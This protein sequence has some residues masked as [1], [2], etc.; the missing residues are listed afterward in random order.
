MQM[1]RRRAISSVGALIAMGAPRMSL[2]Q[3]GP[4]QLGA[5]VPLTGSG[6]SYGPPMAESI[7]WVI[8]Q[9][10]DLGGIKGRS[11]NLTIEDDETNPDSGVRGARKLIDVNRVSAIMG[12]WASSVTMAVAPLC[13]QSQTFLTTDSGS[14]RITQLPHQGYLIRTEPTT[15]LIVTKI[16]NFLADLGVK[17]AYMLSAQTPFAEIAKDTLSRVLSG[18]GSSMLGQTVYDREKTTFRSEIDIAM[19]GNPDLIF[20]DGYSPDVAVLLRELYQTGYT[21]KKLA[22][23]YAVNEKLLATIPTEATEGVITVTPAS[24]V[25]TPSYARLADH[26]KVKEVDSYTCEAYDQANLVCLAL[27]NAAQPNGTGIRD[28]IHSVSD[29]GGT[30]VYSA[31]DGIRALR[32]GTKKI[33]YSGVSG[34][35]IFNKLGDIVDVKA[36]FETVHNGKADLLK[37]T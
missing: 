17:R 35:C 23:A 9:V 25:G 16:G 7:K 28:A 26:L 14:D 32:A 19:K 4:I 34:P 27:Q 1:N 30:V 24:E 13:W 10:N 22:R 11:L 21:G 18:R 33:K 2:A 6:S 12:T 3:S 36:R 8:Q 31:V 37:I 5:L 20:L 15:T 29:P